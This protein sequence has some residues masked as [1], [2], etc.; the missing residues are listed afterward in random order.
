ML[1]QLSRQQVEQIKR[2]NDGSPFVKEM[3]TV[4]NGA[5]L[6]KELDINEND[7]FFL[8]ILKL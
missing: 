6:I 1:S 8:N 7:V 4:K 3:I 2:Q 5:P